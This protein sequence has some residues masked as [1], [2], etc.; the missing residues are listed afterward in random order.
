MGERREIDSFRRET[1][2]TEISQR[3]RRLTPRQR[4]AFIEEFNE[5]ISTQKKHDELLK[6]NDD[7]HPFYHTN[8]ETDEKAV[9]SREK[10][11]LTPKQ[12][13]AF[14]D[15]YNAEF[16]T[17]E[18]RD[19]FVKE[20]NTEHSF[21]RIDAETNQNHHHRKYRTSD[22]S[23]SPEL[24]TGKRFGK[25]R[26]VRVFMPHF[27]QQNLQSP[28]EVIELIKSEYSGVQHRQDLDSLMKT[29]I[30][31]FRLI[32]A[33]DNR[34]KISQGEVKKIAAKL[35]IR[36]RDAIRWTFYSHKPRLY[37]ILSRATSRS[38]AKQRVD[39]IRNGIDGIASW[40]DVQE[41]LT[42]I[43]PLREHETRSLFQSRKHN[44]VDFFRV[45]KEAEKGGTVAGIARRTGIPRNRASAIMNGHLPYLIRLVLPSV[46]RTSTMP[47]LTYDVKIKP[48]EIRG[49][50]V[51][52]IPQLKKIIRGDSP[53]AVTSHN[54]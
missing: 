2:E 9:S 12:R 38:E 52:T 24:K 50:R 44:V 21:R 47:T 11:L 43:Y 10:H 27:G 35:D 51:E 26:E 6:D 17:P 1:E 19:R 4:D 30:D 40:E 49:I 39:E 7:E 48:P 20:Y 18:E 45:L 8:S 31:H 41:K 25:L 23:E 54:C 34:E 42:E 46:E 53:P 3:K 28:G 22:L 15:E 37:E 36:P 16:L 33:L 29:V 13:D 5:E 14:I 32:Y